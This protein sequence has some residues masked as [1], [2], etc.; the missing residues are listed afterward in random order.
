MTYFTPKKY[1]QDP[2]NGG[3]VLNNVTAND[4]ANFSAELVADV[5]G[6]NRHGLFLCDV[7]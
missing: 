3:G 1:Q 7:G 2:T 4:F 6:L 5:D